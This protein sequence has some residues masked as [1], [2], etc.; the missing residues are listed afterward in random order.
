MKFFAVNQMLAYCSRFWRDYILRKIVQ[1]VPKILTQ[2]THILQNI[3]QKGYSVTLFWLTLV[4][5][6]IHEK[7][8]VISKILNQHM[9]RHDFIY[10]PAATGNTKT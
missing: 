1:M 7:S 3:Q 9:Y 6:V 8:K 10:L 2:Y 5:D 4:K